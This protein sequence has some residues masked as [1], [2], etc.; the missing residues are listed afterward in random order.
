MF[1]GVL[2]AKKVFVRRHTGV[3]QAGRSAVRDAM[4]NRTALK[5]NRTLHSIRPSDYKPQAPCMGFDILEQV[6]ES[7]LKA[8]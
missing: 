4:Q 6:H 1:S 2:E 7:H 3:L 8:G 5:P